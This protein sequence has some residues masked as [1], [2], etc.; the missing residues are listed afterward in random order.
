MKEL[1]PFISYVVA[2]FFLLFE[3][4]FLF[5]LRLDSEFVIS[6][7]PKPSPTL[8]KQILGFIRALVRLGDIYL[9]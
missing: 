9:V 7:D 5:I 1:V 3:R 4:V 2:H 6:D 8:T